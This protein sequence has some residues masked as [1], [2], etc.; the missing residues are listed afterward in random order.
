[1]RELNLEEVNEI[2]GGNLTWG[3]VG[4]AIGG[5]LG[6]ALGGLGGA[7]VGVLAGKAVGEFFSCESS[8]NACN[9]N[10][11]MSHVNLTM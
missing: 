10:L 5:A 9:T 3:D 11:N 7:A 8:T 1:M 6:G 2:S 4:S